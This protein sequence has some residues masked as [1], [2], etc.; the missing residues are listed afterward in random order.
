MHCLPWC[1]KQEGNGHQDDGNGCM[2]Y[3]CEHRRQGLGLPPGA[4]SHIHIHSYPID[5]MG[6][7]VNAVASIESE[8]EP[9]NR[10]CKMVRSCLFYVGA[11]GRCNMVRCCLYD[12]RAGGVLDKEFAWTGLRRECR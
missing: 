3:V 8:V 2:P 4:Q 1:Y 6:P 12:V 11:G 7:F 10:T 5:L 9:G